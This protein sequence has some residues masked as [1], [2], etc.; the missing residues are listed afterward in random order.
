MEQEFDLRTYLNVLRRRY[1][2]LL[3]PIIPIFALGCAIAYLI[4]AVYNASAKI[5]VQS[6]QIPTDL[7]RP[8]VTTD[9]SQQIEVI[10]QRLM[11]RGNLLQIARKFSLYDGRGRKLSP[12]EIVEAMREATQ[13][14]HIAVGSRHSR[15]GQQAIA[16]S[17]SFEHGDPNKASNVAN[18]FVA[19]MLEQ[20]IKTRTNR[21]AETHRF[22]VQQVA[23]LDKELAA[24][25]ALIVDFKLKNEATLPESLGYRRVLHTRLQ[26]EQSEI[27]REIGALDAEKERLIQEK[28]GA[29]SA[30]DVNATEAEVAR[31]KLQLTQLRAV[32]SDRHPSVRKAQKRLQALEKVS[33]TEAEEAKQG[34][35]SQEAERKPPGQR[36]TVVSARND[37]QKT[38]HSESTSRGCAAEDLG[39][40][41]EHPEDAPG[42]RRSAQADAQIREA[43]NAAT[44]CT[45]QSG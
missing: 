31:L 45:V 26:S 30:E 37:R 16:F 13:I 28:D 44:Q 29:V 11:T 40:R 38:R 7:A 5:L 33:A 36:Q 18:E 1:L 20:N 24:Q 43:P 8:T 25:E 6:Q 2:Y 9:A 19:L 42:G 34:Q 10:R 39:D 23:K 32:Y 35:R 15:R 14:E 41:R 3:L 12:S 27:D 21:A 22:F 4:P 17:V